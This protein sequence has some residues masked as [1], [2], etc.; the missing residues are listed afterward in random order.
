V[1]PV[2]C[3]ATKTYEMPICNNLIGLCAYVNPYTYVFEGLMAYDDFGLEPSTNWIFT[4]P[5]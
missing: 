1:L 3:T 2:G 4:N 5:V